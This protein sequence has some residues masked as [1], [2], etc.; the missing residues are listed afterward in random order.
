[1]V[2]LVLCVAGL[3]A[4]SMQVRCIDAAREAAR[5]ASR[6]DGGNAV[7]VARSIAPADA[8]VDVRN[9][10][11]SVVATVSARSILLA[12]ITLRAVAVAAIE[13]TAG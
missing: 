6:G 12:G 1:V 11:A 10:G 3:T 8:V 5:L 2:V 9:D 7:Q 4:V 13:P